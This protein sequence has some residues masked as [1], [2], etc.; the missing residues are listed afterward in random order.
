MSVSKLRDISLIILDSIAPAYFKIFTDG[1]VRDG[2]EDGGAGLVFVS[3]V[4]LVHE[5]HAPAVNHCSSYLVE[6]AAIKEAI[7]W[8]SSISSWASAIIICEC[9]SMVQAVSNAT[10]VDSSVIQLQA[11]TAVLAMSKSMCDHCVMSGN[12]LADHR[13]NMG[14]AE[15]KPDN[16]LEPATRRALIGR[17]CRP[18]PIQHEQLKETYTSLPDEQ[19]ETS[20]ATTYHTDL[21]R[22]RSGHH[23]ALRRW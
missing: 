23:P 12:E 9:K 14:A 13:A 19:I 11:S 4:E 15:T 5:W 21:A 22:F 18:P 20:F 8:L 1:T 6:T 7:Q 17:S 2:I 16:A 10:S 3:Q